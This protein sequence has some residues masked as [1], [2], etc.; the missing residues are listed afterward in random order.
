MR[1]GEI[2]D[3]KWRH[4]LFLH[5]QVPIQSLREL[6]PEGLEIDTFAGNAY[7]GL[8][9]FTMPEASPWS[10]VPAISGVTNFH[11]VNVR[12]Y[13]RHGSDRGVW[14]FSL[15]A[16]SRLAVAAARATFRLPYFFASIEMEVNG[17]SV[18]Y[19][20]RRRWPKPLPAD[21]RLD[22]RIAGGATRTSADGSLEH[23]LVERYLLFTESGGKLYRGRVHHQPYALQEAEL[24][25][26]Q[27]TLVWAAGIRLSGMAPHVIYSPGV[28]VQVDPIE[29]LE[30][31]TFM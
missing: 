25:S 7:V 12:T 26:L 15:D 30:L 29:L 8:V 23:F 14:F 17:Q 31:P 6:V 22:Y 16:A 2:I 3:M 5:W 24:E 28:D 11:E 4:L 18:H 21:C 20:S 1:S 9:P 10:V 27:E 13:V 19:E